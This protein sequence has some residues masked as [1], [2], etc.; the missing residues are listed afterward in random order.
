MRR[1]IAIAETVLSLGLNKLIARLGVDPR[2]QYLFWLAIVANEIR[3]LIVALAIAKR[4][5]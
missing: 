5:F 3:G 1:S 2:W 4:I